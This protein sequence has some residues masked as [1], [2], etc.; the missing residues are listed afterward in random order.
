[1]GQ[2]AFAAKDLKFLANSLT[3]AWA[4]DLSK[5][6]IVSVVR[7]PGWQPAIRRIRWLDMLRRESGYMGIRRHCPVLTVHY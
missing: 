6:Y 2:K 5:A 4:G 3:F 1:M 7:E